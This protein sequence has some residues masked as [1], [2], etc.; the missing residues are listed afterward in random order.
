LGLILVIVLLTFGAEVANGMTPEG[1][2]IIILRMYVFLAAFMAGY[3]SVT[4]S[5]QP[6]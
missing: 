5:E 1:T 2:L 6:L 4:T 3:W